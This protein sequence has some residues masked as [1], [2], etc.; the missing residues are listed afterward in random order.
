MGISRMRRLGFVLLGLVLS[1]CILRSAPVDNAA[2]RSVDSLKELEGVYQNLGEGASA[3]HPVYLSSLIWPSQGIPHH[4]ITTVSVNAHD[5]ET[6][7][8]RAF[9]DEHIEREDTFVRARDFRFRDGRI[10][11][12]RRW[13]PLNYGGD[14]PTVGPRYEIYEL[15]LDTE[16][17]GKYR[18]HASFAGLVLM[19]F[20]AAISATEE[21]RFLRLAP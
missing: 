17:S 21:V 12:S 14:D 20:P 5:E 6:L 3:G 10:L 2:F 13:A 11:L 7:I 16:G 15:G 18:S 9:R 1:G 19:I 8:V 4:S